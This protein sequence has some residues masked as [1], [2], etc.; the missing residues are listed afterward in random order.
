MVNEFVPEMDDLDIFGDED[1]QAPVPDQTASTDSAPAGKQE[2]AKSEDDD[3][4]DSAGEGTEENPM[5]FQG[6]RNSPRGFTT[7]YAKNTKRNQTA[8]NQW[9][10]TQ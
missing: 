10:C 7:K 3:D 5:C 8:R 2:P 4:D 9:I 1:D 6:G